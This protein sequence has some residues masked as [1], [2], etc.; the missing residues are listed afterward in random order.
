MVFSKRRISGGKN[1]KKK[2]NYE[3]IRGSSSIKDNATIIISSLSTLPIDYT[4][5]QT[6]HKKGEN[7]RDGRTGNNSKHWTFRRR[8]QNPRKEKKNEHNDEETIKLERR[9]ARFAKEQLEIKSNESKEFGLVSRGQDNRLQNDSSARNMLLDDTKRMID[10][11]R[12][13]DQSLETRDQILMNFRKLRESILRIK[14]DEF[15]KSVLLASMHF[16]ITIEHYQS[17]IPTMEKLIERESIDA[18][19]LKG[20]EL[21]EV[22]LYF[23]LH[24][25]HF[26][27]EYER[28]FSL[29]FEVTGNG[30]RYHK[31]LYSDTIESMTN[32]QLTY[33]LI[34]AFTE[35]NYFKWLQ[36]YNYLGTKTD[37]QV[38]Q[39]IRSI[40]KATAL[41]DTLEDISKT[42]Q[43]SYFVLDYPFF[44][45]LLGINASELVSI[46]K[47]KWVLDDDAGLV[48][49]RERVQKQRAIKKA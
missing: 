14:S 40:L 37:D 47:A 49:L 26:S 19:F 2:K 39:H 24:I 11:Y 41:Q 1:K 34:E 7:N 16:S 32:V 42:L 46:T 31:M 10:D 25:V 23:I 43:S 36:I 27:K 4:T 12:H 35:H 30:Q 45:G 15:V 29:L 22:W 28:G 8:T 21:E 44:K 48:T 3:P 17:Y 9:K 13:K 5:M 20:K 6:N 33:K 18:T 38:K